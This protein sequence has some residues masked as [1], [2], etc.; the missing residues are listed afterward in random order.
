VEHTWH[1]S[2]EDLS[3]RLAGVGTIILFGNN[4]GVFGTHQRARQM[5]ADWARASPPAARILAGSTNPYAGG[6]PAIDRNYYWANKRSGRPPGRLRIRSRYRGRVGKWSDWIFV[7]REEMRAAIK[8]TGWHV[9][10]VVGGRPS[11][12]YVAILEKG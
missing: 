5:L 7:S 2:I 8:G 4:F 3:S 9:A 6:A 11:E 1:L 12:S 10:R